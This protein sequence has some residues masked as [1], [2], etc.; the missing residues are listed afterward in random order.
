M[1]ID[2][3]RPEGAAAVRRALARGPE[4]VAEPDC[5]VWI[6]PGWRAEAGPLGAWLL[7]HDRASR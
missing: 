5:T 1:L 4:V 6:A 7:T 2:L 3:A